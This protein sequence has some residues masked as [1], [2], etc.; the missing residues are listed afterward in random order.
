M[1]DQGYKNTLEIPSKIA[2][3]I[4]IAMSEFKEDDNDPITPMVC[5]PVYGNTPNSKDLSSQLKGEDDTVAYFS[6]DIY[7]DVG[8]QRDSGGIVSFGT[9]ALWLFGRKSYNLVNMNIR[10]FRAMGFETE[11]GTVGKN[12]S[13]PYLKGFSISHRSNTP[14]SLSS[15]FLVDLLNSEDI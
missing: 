7:P 2:Q 15:L 3:S 1:L 13:V 9:F 8:L 4:T 5:Y 14:H 10:T 6:C 12:T 11:A